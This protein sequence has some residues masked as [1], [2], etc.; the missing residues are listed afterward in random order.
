MGRGRAKAKQT[1]VARELKYFSPDTD[2]QSLQKELAQGEPGSPW[3]P[4][5]TAREA[6]GPDG[7]G[8]EADPYSGYAEADVDDE[9]SWTPRAG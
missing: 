6:D 5:P 4:T 3:R 9:D 2:L 8:A 7:S 1:K